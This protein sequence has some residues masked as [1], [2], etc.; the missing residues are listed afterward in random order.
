MILE[1][2]EPGRPYN[3]CTGRTIEIR[4][5]LEMLIA[6]AKVPVTIKVDPARIRPND[7]P[8]LV[9]D[10]TRLR[11]E[12]GWGPEI[13]LEQTVDDLLAYWRGTETQ[14]LKS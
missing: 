6:R 2:G 14:E 1:R 10:P 3:V 4:E 13:S 12:T 7:A 9:G 11:D 8:I 5:L